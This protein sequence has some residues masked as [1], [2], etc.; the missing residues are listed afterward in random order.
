M[1]LGIGI[2]GVVGGLIATTSDPGSFT[3]M[4][5]LDAATFLVFAAVLAAVREP[6]PDEP[7]AAEEGRLR[8]SRAAI[9]RACAITTSSRSPASTSSSWRSGTRC[10]RYCHR[11][12][13]TTP[14]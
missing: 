14:G 3:R 11:S 8:R 6:Y 5:M 9:A 10:S 1:N 2:G 4:F 13:R 7:E 12:R